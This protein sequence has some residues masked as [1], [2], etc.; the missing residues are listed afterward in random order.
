METAHDAPHCILCDGYLATILQDVADSRFGI[1]ETYAICKCSDCQLVQL[2][3]CPSSHELKE[4]YED[5]Y[6]F[7]GGNRSFYSKLRSAFLNSVLY[8]IWMLMDGDISFHARPGKGRL[9]D[10][11]CNEGRSL[12]IYKRNGFAVEGLELNE[13]AAA[14]ARKE[15]FIIHTELLEN[16]QPGALYDVVV[17]SNVLEHALQPDEML[18]HVARILN[19]RGE[20]WVSCP[21]IDSWQRERFARYWINWHVPFHIVQF[22]LA[23]LTDLLSKNSFEPFESHNISPALWTAHSAIAW[24]FFRHGR[25]TAQLRNPFLV[26]FLMLLFRGLFF[27]GLWL[28]NLLQRGDCLVVVA[29]KNSN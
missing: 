3:P 12:S 16:Y 21:N 29:R 10:V 20:V 25:P 7:G 22:S 2:Y 4:L 19:P 27:P 13:R 1:L 17:L 26:A 23:T 18:I 9:L 5:H 6:N 24:K 8:R 11:G 14:E 15:G 28:G